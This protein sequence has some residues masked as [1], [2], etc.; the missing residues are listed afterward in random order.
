MKIL[1]DNS[2]QVVKLFEREASALQWLNQLGTPKVEIDGYFIF[3]PSNNT[4]QFHCLV[5]EKIEGHNLE[6]WLEQHGPISE[7][8]ALNWLRQLIEI[9]DQVHQKYLFHRDIKP[10][11]IM[12]RP[13]GQLALIDFG[14]VREITDTYL[15]KVRA[16]LDITQIISAGYTPPGCVA[17]T[18]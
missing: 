1:K 11:N 10:S 3:S 18:I 15:A 16:G 12:V 14:S 5:M 2:P 13:N 4:Q 17:K 6:Q 7:S 8:L 9:L